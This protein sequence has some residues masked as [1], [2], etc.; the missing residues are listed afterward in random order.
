[1]CYNSRGS[2]CSWGKDDTG[3]SSGNLSPTLLFHI[4]PKVETGDADEQQ[5]GCWALCAGNWHLV[6]VGFPLSENMA[7]SYP[8]PV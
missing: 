8:Q 2:A 7:P 6:R 4:E 1:M 5:V 3:I